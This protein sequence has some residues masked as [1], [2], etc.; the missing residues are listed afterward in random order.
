MNVRSATTLFGLLSLGAFGAA[1][2]QTSP[3]P[4]TADITNQAFATFTDAAGNSLSAESNTVTTDVLPIYRF[5]ITPNGTDT[6]AGV[7][8]TV[9]AAV[10]TNAVFRYTLENQGNTAAGNEVSLATLQ[11]TTDAFTFGTPTIYLDD[12]DGVFDAG[13]TAVTSATVPYGQSVVLFVVAPIPGTVTNGQVGRLDLTGDAV[14]SADVDTGNYA[15]ANAFTYASLTLSKTASPASPTTVA[16]G[17]TISY[18]LSGNNQGGISPFAVDNVVTIDN[19]S[20]LTPSDGILIT[21]NFTDTLA[22]VSGS[23]SLSGTNTTGTRQLLYSVNNGTTWTTAQPASGVNAVAL[24]IPGTVGQRVSATTQT[25]SYG[26][27]FQV[28]VPAGQASGSSISNVGNLRYDKDGEGDTLD[29]GEEVSSNPTT[30]PV[31]A[32][33][34][35]VVGPFEDADASGI[36][37]ATYT[38]NGMTITRA[39]DTQTIASAP[40]GR[41][42]WFQHSL[43]NDANFSDTFTFS[44]S[45]PAGFTGTVR[46]YRVNPDGSLGSEI[47]VANPLAVPAG[48]TAEFYVGIDLPGDYTTTT[49]ID[50]VTTATSSTNLATVTDTTTDRISAVTEAQGVNIGNYAPPAEPTDPDNNPATQTTA[51]GTTVSFPLAVKNNGVDTDTFTLADTGPFAATT[52]LYSDANN[53]GIIDGADAIVTSTGPIL[54]G[55]TVYFIAVVTVPAGTPATDYPVAVTTTSTTDATITDT[56]TNTV[57]VGVVGTF[58]FAPD[59]TQTVPANTTITYEHTLTNSQNTPVFV[60]LAV[61]DAGTTGWIYE[62]SVNGGA[63]TTTVPQDISLAAGASANVTVQVTIPAGVP[64]GTTDTFALTATP[65]R[66]STNP[67]NDFTVT[68]TT[69][70]NANPG[71]TIALVKTVDQAA[72][73]P[74]EVLTYTVIATNTGAST[75]TNVAIRDA[76][77]ANTSFVSVS[78]TSSVTGTVLYSTNGTTWSTSAPTT[79]AT[80]GTVYVGVDT[81]ASGSITTD[82]TVSANGTVTM[83]FQV[84]IN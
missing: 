50:F 53:N 62:Y 81:N 32:S 9:D 51:P 58:T 2:A 61:T 10:G 45:T 52:V 1:F 69:I 31:G 5:A 22:Y 12:G 37:P 47:T 13:D 83:T 39:G 15:Q 16:P 55:D 43:A 54:A 33:G 18:T 21:D 84:R 34:A 29:P 3:T 76:V 42:E 63:F 36:T 74:G 48:T 24:F 4:D 17:D 27:T 35:F 23:L 75:V 59:G 25:F 64:N 56:I 71:G 79:V 41:L 19:G 7:G 44:S 70:V 28:R 11:S 57:T 66:V 38:L 77:P 8:Q 78:G 6:A 30:N 49:P 46:Y 67:A 20:T 26:Y 14:N 72:A 40:N 82:D 65:D 80:G 60:D 68:D 73:E